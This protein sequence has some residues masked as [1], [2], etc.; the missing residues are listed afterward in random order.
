MSWHYVK[1]IRDNC[2]DISSTV[3]YVS[4]YISK[5]VHLLRALCIYDAIEFSLEEL[6]NTVENEK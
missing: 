4:K 5:Q 1:E 3:M 6:I 2:R